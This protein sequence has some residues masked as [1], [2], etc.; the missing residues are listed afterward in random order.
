MGAARGADAELPGRHAG[1]A[2]GPGAVRELAPGPDL[3]GRGHG[4]RLR[5]RASHRRPGRHVGPAGHDGRA[6]G[7][8]R[9]AAAGR[10]GHQRRPAGGL[11]RPTRPG[12]LAA[13]GQ[14]LPH[15]LPRARVLDLLHQHG[16]PPA[17]LQ[18]GLPARAGAPAG[19]AAACRE[20]PGARAG[21]P[22]HDEG[23]RA[24][25]PAV[26]GQLG[27]PGGPLRGRGLRQARRADRGRGG[28]ALRSAGVGAAAGVRSR[29]RR[30]LLLVLGRGAQ[31]RG[32]GGVLPAP[33]GLAAGPG[34]PQHAARL[35]R[36][37][38]VRGRDPTGADGAAREGA[39]GAGHA[40]AALGLLLGLRPGE[41]RAAAALA[42]AR[43][44]P[45]RHALQR[46][47]LRLRHLLPSAIPL[48]AAEGEAPDHG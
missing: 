48:G 33:A 45:G 44:R 36:A 8:G 13:P 30:R 25:L 11:R 28:K 23:L 35:L 2:Q 38:G 16:R 17:L 43:D 29:R 24:D 41:R 32:R 46:R 34:R 4:L 7:A 18:G 1:A 26:P 19:A 37:C 39:G 27:R 40:A 3:L 21:P 22:P 42:G 31:H 10:R 9:G 14:V 20:A 15:A 6:S 47:L 12:P 5:R